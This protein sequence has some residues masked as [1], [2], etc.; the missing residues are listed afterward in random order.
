LSKEGLRDH[1]KSSPRDHQ[2][3]AGGP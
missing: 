1:L 2:S 3:L